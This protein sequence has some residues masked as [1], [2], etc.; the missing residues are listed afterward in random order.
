MA[1]GHVWTRD[2]IFNCIP[3]FPNLFSN[4]PCSLMGNYTWHPSPHPMGLEIP[5]PS[6]PPRRETGI[7]DPSCR[8][9]DPT[10]PSSYIQTFSIKLNK[11]VWL[12]FFFFFLFF[13][14]CALR[15]EGV[16][17]CFSNK[18]KTYRPTLVVWIGFLSY[19]EAL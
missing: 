1:M 14:F 16:N 9:R 18:L 10:M 6:P 4:L 12:F 13:F 2:V 15:E 11:H 7:R 8:A 17:K 19:E 3:K 5:D